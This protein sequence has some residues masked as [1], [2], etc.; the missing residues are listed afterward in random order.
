[1]AAATDSA[2]VDPPILQRGL[3]GSPRQTCQA[4]T[5][6]VRERDRKGLMSPEWAICAKRA[7]RFWVIV[8]WH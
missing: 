2:L 4:I 6:L 3:A 8:E 5:W 1:V 7:N